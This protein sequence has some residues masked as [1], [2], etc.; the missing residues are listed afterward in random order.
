MDNRNLA[1]NSG[2]VTLRHKKNGREGLE[3]KIIT[4]AALIP[5]T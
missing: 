5:H 2:T 1:T 4:A 3:M